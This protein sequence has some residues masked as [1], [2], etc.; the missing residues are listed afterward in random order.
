MTLGNK[1][2]G[3]SSGSDLCRVPGEGRSDEGDE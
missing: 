2:G 1:L 3:S